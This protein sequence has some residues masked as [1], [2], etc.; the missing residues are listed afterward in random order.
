MAVVSG[1]VHSV[2]TIERYGGSV[3]NLQIA[4]V[5]FTVSGT[6]AQADDGILED[7]DDLIA[8]S[9]RNGKTITLV[10]A[11]PGHPATKSSDPSAILGLE[12]VSV[13]SADVVFT[14]TNGDYTTEFADATAVPAQE[15]PFA[16]LVAFTEA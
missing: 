14:I 11:M 12:A 3:S 13:S 15:R 4:E 6:Y 5:L 9:R 10:D 7:V 1:T 2:S 16:V 8:A